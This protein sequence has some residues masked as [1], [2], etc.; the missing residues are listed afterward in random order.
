M[1]EDDRTVYY[2]QLKILKEM[3]EK[4]CTCAKVVDYV[5][6]NLQKVGNVFWEKNGVE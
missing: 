5:V 3:E 2:I 1:Y 4:Q 6:I